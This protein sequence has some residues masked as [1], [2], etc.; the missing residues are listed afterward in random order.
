MEKFTDDGMMAA[1]DFVRGT[2]GEDF[3]FVDHSDAMG[4][5]KSEVTVMGN[6]QRSD[7]D[8]PMEGTA[9]WGDEGG[10]TRY[11]RRPW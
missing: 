6:H 11:G 7:A 8:A 9:T 2:D 3:T 4:N 5:A 1:P 10:C